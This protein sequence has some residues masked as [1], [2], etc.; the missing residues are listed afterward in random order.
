[1]GLKGLQILQLMYKFI[2]CHP[3]HM[4]IK[5]KE[6]RNII[7]G[8]PPTT[9]CEL[10]WNPLKEPGKVPLWERHQKTSIPP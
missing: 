1:M 8:F 10:T 5:R 6:I 2:F 4:K 9:K 3:C 7:K